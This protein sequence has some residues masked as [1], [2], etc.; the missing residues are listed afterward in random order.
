MLPVSEINYRENPLEKDN[1]FTSFLPSWMV[2]TIFVS[3]N[4]LLSK[5]EK[6]EPALIY[7]VSK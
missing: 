3:M 6:K 1:S 2:E 5:Q 4:K 7:E